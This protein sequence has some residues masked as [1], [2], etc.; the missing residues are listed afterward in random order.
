MPTPMVIKFAKQT[1]KPVAEVEKLWDKAKESAKDNGWEESEDG[2]YPYV[3]GILK[4]MLGIKDTLEEQVAYLMGE[5][6]EE[7]EHHIEDELR[8]TLKEVPMKVIVE[9]KQSKFSIEQGFLLK[10]DS[11]D[12]RIRKT[13]S[14]DGDESYSM[15]MKFRPLD[16]E[17]E[18][19]ISQEMFDAFWPQAIMKQSKTR[20][21]WM[22]WDIDELENG[23]VYA[24][25]ERG[26]GEKP[27]IPSCF[28][29]LKVNNG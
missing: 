1:G 6:L 10:I 29:V 4:S 20:Y 14:I 11:A 8:L 12:L 23:E 16:Q 19:K 9:S 17:A 28:D 24:E 13:T 5:V 22:G 21:V 26:E 2:F 27:T 18:T 3:V 15:A 7:E 25:F